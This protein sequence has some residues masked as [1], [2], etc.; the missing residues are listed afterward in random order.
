MEGGGEKKTSESK[1][2]GTADSDDERLESVHFFDIFENENQHELKTF[3]FDG[4]SFNIDTLGEHMQ[5]TYLLGQMVW[6]NA[7]IL[8]HFIVKHQHL[9]KDKSVL[10]VGAGPGL[11]G[12]VAS[13]YCKRV[14]LTD[15]D[16]KV[17]ALLNRNIQNNAHLGTQMEAHKL[18]WGV[19]V[20]EFNK[21]FGPFDIIIGSGVVYESECIPPLLETCHTLLPVN[22]RGFPSQTKG[23]HDDGD[24]DQDTGGMVI[25][26]TNNYRYER[27]K[28]LFES[29][30]KRLGLK[31]EFMDM[32]QLLCW[33]KAEREKDP[34]CIVQEEEFGLIHICVITKTS[35]GI[36]K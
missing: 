11:S 33:A 13:V 23:A 35:G 18:A 4:H 20:D 25:L 17:V 2:T 24:R 27:R 10:E 30:A 5:D 32:K 36:E 28:E 14:V 21:K 1:K 26:S 8:C 29:T 34:Q 6:P 31:Q 15:Y 16:E 7:Q 19:G 22:D 12:I 3:R 9:F